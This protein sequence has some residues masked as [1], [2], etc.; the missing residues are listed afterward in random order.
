MLH[1]FETIIAGD[2]TEPQA[3]SIINYLYRSIRL[4]SKRTSKLTTIYGNYSMLTKLDGNIVTR[5]G[6]NTLN[7]TTLFVLYIFF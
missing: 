2:C 1:R 6:H 3:S 4:R 7:V 5:Y